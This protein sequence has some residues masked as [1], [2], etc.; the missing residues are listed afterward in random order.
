MGLGRAGALL[1]IT[2]ICIEGLGL[3]DSEV[4]HVASGRSMTSTVVVRWFLCVGT[5]LICIEG[6]RPH[7]GIAPSPAG[8]S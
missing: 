7:T 8:A 1:G 2:L 5:A 4:G 6:L 3:G